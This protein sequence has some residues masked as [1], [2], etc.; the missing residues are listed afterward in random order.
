MCLSHSISCGRQQ[1]GGLIEVGLLIP[2]SCLRKT[3][4]SYNAYLKL[5]LCFYSTSSDLCKSV[6]VF[7]KGGH[8]QTSFHLLI[9]FAWPN[10]LNYIHMPSHLSAARGS[11][12]DPLV[13]CLC[14]HK[15]LYSVSAPVFLHCLRARI[16]F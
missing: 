15:I 11:F 14:Y 8:S 12:L 5:S 9:R 10:F 16:Q 4:L 13:S 1:G 2:A 7:V 3:P 6:I